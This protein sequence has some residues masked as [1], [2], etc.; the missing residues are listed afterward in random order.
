[1]LDH[2]PKGANATI[3]VIQRTL[4][5]LESQGPLPEVLYLQMDNCWRENKN[6]YL[7][8][9]LALLV[10]RRIFRTVFIHFLPKGHT[11]EDIDQMFSR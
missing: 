5:H 6:R 1:M 9:Y 4:R 2:W 7:F 8:G 10:F 3:E 11:H